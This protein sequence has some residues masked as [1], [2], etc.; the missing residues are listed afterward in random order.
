MRRTLRVPNLPALLAP[1]I[2]GLLASFW[3]GRHDGND[4][5]P[6]P[7]RRLARHGRSRRPMRGHGPGSADQDTAFD[8]LARHAHGRPGACGGSPATPSPATTQI[9][10]AAGLPVDG[11]GLA[12]YYLLSR[13]RWCR[14]PVEWRRCAGL[15]VH[16]RSDNP[17]CQDRVR[18]RAAANPESSPRTLRRRR[19]SHQ[20][21]PAPNAHRRDGRSH[22]I[23]RASPSGARA[24]HR[25]QPVSRRAMAPASGRARTRSAPA[26][27]TSPA[28]LHHR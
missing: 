27:S 1:R 22:D 14:E 18:A 15:W 17:S 13:C 10:L 25:I 5:D 8:A 11:P 24:G 9:E 26:H 3:P 4:C 28:P 23:S 12:R 2:L 7:Q 21:G 19:P 16:R 6:A 20:P